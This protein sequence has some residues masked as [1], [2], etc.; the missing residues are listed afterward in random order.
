MALTYLDSGVDQAGKDAT[1]DKILRMMRK[2]HDPGV[3]DLPWGFAGLYSLKT[4]SLFDTKYRHPVLAACT[5]SVGTKV[6]LAQRLG[7]HDTIG[8]D[9]VAMCVNDLIVTGARPLFFLDYIGCGKS[10]RSL[11]TSIA[12]GVITGCQQSESRLPGGGTCLLYHEHFRGSGRL[13]ARTKRS[14]SS[15]SSRRRRFTCAAHTEHVDATLQNFGRPAGGAARRR[16][17]TFLWSGP[18][19]LVTVQTG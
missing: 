18:T 2:T 1:V 7:K 12:K 9:C 14:A 11:V 8:I 13:G 3:I 5:D 6:K 16:V 4:S 10:N 17:K 15:L 19:R